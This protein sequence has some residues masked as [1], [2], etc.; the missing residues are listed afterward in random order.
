MVSN[1]K[2]KQQNKN[3]FS[4]LDESDAEFTIRHSNHEAR[5]EIRT[6]VLD[7]GIFPNKM[8]GPIQVNSQQVDMHTLEEN[9]LS[10]K[11]NWS[12]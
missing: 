4:Q 2:K 7:I 3:L 10:K 11:T 8:N 12:G 5:A 1:G 9:I 6:T